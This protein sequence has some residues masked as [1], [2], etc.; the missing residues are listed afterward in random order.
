MA[1][2][3]VVKI[4]GGALLG[5]V[6]A[7]L[8]IKKIIKQEICDGLKPTID[9]IQKDIKRHDKDINGS[10]TEEKH[11]LICGM[12]SQLVNQKIDSITDHIDT[13][14]EEFARRLD[15]R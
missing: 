10:L 14:F 8:G 9:S 15:K 3:E 6:V 13:K 2:M 4:G 1:E 12:T 7:F 11:K 5:A